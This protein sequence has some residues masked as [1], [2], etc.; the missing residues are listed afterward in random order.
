MSIWYYRDGEESKGPLSTE[1][2]ISQWNA[3]S[4]KADC[5]V[6]QEGME[7]WVTSS[8]IIPTLI[9]GEPHLSM[10]NSSEPQESSSDETLFGQLTIPPVSGVPR[11]EEATDKWYCTVLFVVSGPVSTQEIIKFWEEG[12]FRQ[13]DEIWKGTMEKRAEIG[14]VMPKLYEMT[15]KTAAPENIKCQTLQPFDIECPVFHWFFTKGEDSQP[16][17]PMTTRQLL[18]CWKNNKLTSEH[19]IWKEGMGDWVCPTHILPNLNLRSR[20]FLSIV[21][22]IVA[23][24][25]NRVGATTMLKPAGGG[26]ELDAA[27]QYR[28]V[29]KD[30]QYPDMVWLAFGAGILSFFGMGPVMALPSIIAGHVA[31]QQTKKSPKKYKGEKLAKKALITG[32]TGLVL[33]TLILL[34]IT[35]PQYKLFLVKQDARKMVADITEI[36]SAAITFA[37]Q[38]KKKQITVVT[39]EE[40]K[41]RKYF[42]P[43]SPIGQGKYSMKLVTLPPDLDYEKNFPQIEVGKTFD[44]PAK[45]RELYK[46]SIPLDDPI[47]RINK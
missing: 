10:P 29:Q 34:F 40:I 25:L 41:K 21:A 38:N 39:F 22:P 4:L 1:E 24:D 35:I 31:L 33:G 14:D 16:E 45:Y 11:E 42:H 3:G 17:G 9:E 13:D 28:V 37:K 26:K 46:E 32:Y 5:L 8:H 7:S 6:W 12:V 15:H 18:E 19:L 47:W 36:K 2:L 20:E 27:A 30:P 23:D 44:V 43:A